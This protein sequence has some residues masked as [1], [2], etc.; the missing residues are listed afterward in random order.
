MESLPNYQDGNILIV[1]DDAG[2]LTSAQLFLKQYF[3]KVYVELNPEKIKNH[4]NKNQI[5][6][7]LLDMNFQKGKNNGE[8][9]FKYLKTILE[10]QPNVLVIF[11]TAYG[12]IDMAVQALKGGA[13]DFVT[14]PWK[15]EKFLT[16]IETANKLAQ[17]R[18]QIEDL[19]NSRQYLSEQEAKETEGFIGQAPLFLQ[20]KHT[21][22]KVSITD[23]SVL[24]LGQNGTGKGLAAKF[25]HQNSLRNER[26]MIT[27]DMGALSESIM[28]SELFG[29]EKG[30]F[31]DASQQK[32][33]RLELAHKG[34]LFLD[35]IG[36]LSLSAQAKLLSVLQNQ[37]FSRLGS[38]VEIDIDV[39]LICATN[40][41]LYEMVEQG[42]FR[43]DLLYRINTVELV[44]PSLNDRLIDIPILLDYFLSA[45]KA[46]YKKRALN[47][48]PDEVAKLQRMNWPGNI[49]EFQHATERAVILADQDNLRASDFQNIRA[50]EKSSP[51]S[52]SLNL[53][54][55]EIAFIE[56]AMKIH[57]GNITHAAKE[58]GIDRLALHRRLEKYGI[59]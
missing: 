5:D 20:V 4:F 13:I 48:S 43:Q 39:R 46:R 56:K 47:I 51:P 44:M 31:T 40:M 15:N 3:K 53:K 2:I 33:G 10:I 58:L 36:N 16:T 38:N 59:Q 45:F 23:A 25:I 6:I 21:M 8:D 12:D 54:D 32:K 14:K 24:L 11:M 57:L 1:D 9:G 49:R 26:P 27:I 42:T 52:D 19:K 35:E 50:A 55:M 34:T 7:V 18:R 41:P 29:H 22:E 17:S 37:K 28:E 30:S